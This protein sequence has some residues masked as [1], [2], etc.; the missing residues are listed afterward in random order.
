MFFF[1][2][3]LKQLRE[4]EKISTQMFVCFSVVHFTKSC[5][6]RQSCLCNARR[7]QAF[8]CFKNTNQ[9]LAQASKASEDLLV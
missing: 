3:S 4:K 7:Q 6:V 2:L 5:R 1:L 9:W 8:E